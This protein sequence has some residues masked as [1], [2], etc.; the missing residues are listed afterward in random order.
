MLVTGLTSMSAIAILR[1]PRKTLAE[2]T[3]VVAR[4]V[5]RTT[6]AVTDTSKVVT[7]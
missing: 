2:I 6:S 1:K 4:F 5:A 3:E 7:D